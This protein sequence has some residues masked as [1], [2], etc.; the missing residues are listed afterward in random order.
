MCLGYY[1]AETTWEEAQERFRGSARVA[2][3]DRWD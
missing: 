2:I 3:A 1:Q